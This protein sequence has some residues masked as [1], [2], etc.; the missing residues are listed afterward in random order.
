[1]SDKYKFLESLKRLEKA[2]ILD[3][4]YAEAWYQLGITLCNFCKN[5]RDYDDL[6]QP[7]GQKFRES[8]LRA[9]E[10]FKKADQM[11]SSKIMTSLTKSML[12][13]LFLQI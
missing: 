7:T 9:F 10:S 13:Q 1:M 2:V 11:N 6:Q 8:M 4:R 5:C 12:S 3:L